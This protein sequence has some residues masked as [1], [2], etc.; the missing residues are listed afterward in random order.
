VLD[1]AAGD[2]KQPAYLEVHPHGFVPALR[3]D[4]TMVFETAAICMHLADRFPEKGLAPAPGTPDRA[5][6]YQ[7][8]VYSVATLEPALAD[9]FVQGQRS[10]SERDPAV[11]RSARERFAQSAAVL[12]K[13]LSRSYLVG[14]RFGVADILVG[15]MLVWGVAMG[16]LEGHPRLAEYA[17][18]ISARPAFG[19]S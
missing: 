3:D 9:I 7:W 4:D 19:R 15:S 8:V 17:G 6:Y 1:L 14:G 11:L 10:E 2:N 12:E 5:A 16:L 18:Q 13:A